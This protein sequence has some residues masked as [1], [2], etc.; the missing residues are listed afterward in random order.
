MQTQSSLYF[1]ED[2]Y[3]E[4][5]ARLMHDF[6]HANPYNIWHCD[7]THSLLADDL[8]QKALHG[9]LDPFGFVMQLFDAGYTAQE[10]AEIFVRADTE[11]HARQMEAS[12]EEILSQ[13]SHPLIGHDFLYHRD[14]IGLTII[15]HRGRRKIYHTTTAEYRYTDLYLKH[16]FP[17][18][19]QINSRADLYET[20]NNR[21]AKYMEAPTHD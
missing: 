19:Q 16:Y 15:N 6:P 8:W 18:A 10:A 21:H 4:H 13:F 17:D 7:F 2:A 12:E 11:R 14:D 3:L 20:A 9:H 1:P 5:E